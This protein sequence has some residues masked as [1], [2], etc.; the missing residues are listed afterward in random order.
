MFCYYKCQSTLSIYLKAKIAVLN[1]NPLLGDIPVK[2]V[3]RGEHK[4]ITFCQNDWHDLMLNVTSIS[5][6]HWAGVKIL[7]IN[8]SRVHHHINI[9]LVHHHNNGLRTPLSETDK[10]WNKQRNIH[11]LWGAQYVWDSINSWHLISCLVFEGQS[12]DCH[13]GRCDVTLIGVTSYS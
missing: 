7:C 5:D 2:Y 3:K 13:T 8:I 10:N 1:G 4:R 9:S 12:F 11:S 6:F